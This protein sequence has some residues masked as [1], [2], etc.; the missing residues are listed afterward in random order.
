MSESAL[1]IDQKTHGPLLVFRH[2]HSFS[3]RLLDSE[4]YIIPS[5]MSF[6]FPE[7]S[8]TNICNIATEPQCRDQKHHKFGVI[9]VADTSIDP[10]A[11]MTIS[12]ISVQAD[13]E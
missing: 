10:D 8:K 6:Q 7:N 11:V 9:R 1:K 5:F 13:F 12:F 2:L 4:Y 3:S